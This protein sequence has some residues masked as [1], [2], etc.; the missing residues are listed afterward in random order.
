MSYE[1]SVCY[2]ISWLSWEKII[3]M[4]LPAFQFQLNA[5]KRI[6]NAPI[7][8]ALAAIQF[9]TKCPQSILNN[10]DV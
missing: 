5:F 4:P 8:K 1:L 10:C 9:G 6:I 2:P 7:L 3:W